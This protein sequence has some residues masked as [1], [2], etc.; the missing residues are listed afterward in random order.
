MS[1][2]IGDIQR[3]GHVHVHVHLHVMFSI[4]YIPVQYVQ[5]HTQKELYT[6]LHVHAMYM[7]VQYIL[8]DHKSSQHRCRQSPTN[9][10]YIFGSSN[11]IN[12]RRAHSLPRSLSISYKK[13]I[14]R[15]TRTYIHVCTHVHVHV[16]QLTI[17]DA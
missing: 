2:C 12:L 14:G 9:Q 13:K 16:P 1:T 5:I 4:S 10:S 15:S 7:Y 6:E 8:T 11:G 3:H 17:T